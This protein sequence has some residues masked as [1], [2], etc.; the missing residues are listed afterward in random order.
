MAKYEK[1]GSHS[2]IETTLEVISRKWT[3]LVLLEIISGTQR[4][5]ELQ[6]TLRGISPRTLSLRLASLEKTGIIE[7]T[8]FPEVP[9]RVEYRLTP[10]GRT[11]EPILSAMEKWGSALQ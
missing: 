11:L 2:A 6:K 8:V 3:V 10:L 7:R 9:P 4:F 5:S 1:K